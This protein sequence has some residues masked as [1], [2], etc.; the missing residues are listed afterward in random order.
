L[1]HSRCQAADAPRTP[2]TYAGVK[3]TRSDARCRA[4]PLAGSAP[5]PTRVVQDEP[6]FTKVPNIGPTIPKFR[7]VYPKFDRFEWNRAWPAR[8]SRRLVWMIC[9]AWQ[10]RRPTHNAVPRRPCQL[11]LPKRRDG[12]A[13]RG[14]ARGARRQRR[15]TALPWFRRSGHSTLVFWLFWTPHVLAEPPSCGNQDKFSTQSFVQD[16]RLAVD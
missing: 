16:F 15:A 12:S 6:N 14:A 13:R 8:R 10:V 5:A 7:S 2:P 3:P 9:G 1:R 4:R 11:Y